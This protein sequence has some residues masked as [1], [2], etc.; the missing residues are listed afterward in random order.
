MLCP[1]SS[2][3]LG[4]DDMC[5]DRTASPSIGNGQTVLGHDSATDRERDSRA[6]RRFWTCHSGVTKH[7]REG[8]CR[9]AAE[10][11]FH[12]TALTR[13]MARP[14]THTKSAGRGRARP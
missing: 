5:D 6:T 4:G 1:A 13:V 8:D 2:R 14:F 9:L 11:H 7:H 3:R 12:N 10:K